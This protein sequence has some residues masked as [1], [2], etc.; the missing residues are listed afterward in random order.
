METLF[1]FLIGKP[2]LALVLTALW[3]GLCF[4]LGAYIGHRFSLVRDRRKEFNDIADIIRSNLTARRNALSS[5]HSVS[6]NDFE[7]LL[8]RTSPRKR[9]RLSQAWSE[10]QDAQD[11]SGNIDADGFY[12]FH[13]PHILE[14][15]IDNLLPFVKR[16]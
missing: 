5:Q 3:S 8:S 1:P 14:K 16:K 10:Y 12:D 11:A 4:M 6:D 2:V 15:A 9:R 13:S 7:C